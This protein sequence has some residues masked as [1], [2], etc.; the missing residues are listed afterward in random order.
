M[1]RQTGWPNSPG[2]LLDPCF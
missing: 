2:I 1:G